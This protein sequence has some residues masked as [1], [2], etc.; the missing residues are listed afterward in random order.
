MYTDCSIM[1]F[2]HWSDFI[3]NWS[4]KKKTNTFGYLL[5]TIYTTIEG[6]MAPK[7]ID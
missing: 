3:L 7:E 4:K 6:S 1:A 5:T 2:L